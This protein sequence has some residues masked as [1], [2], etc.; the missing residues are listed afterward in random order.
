MART[1][2]LQA[3][4]FFDSK[5]RLQNYGGK[6]AHPEKLSEHLQRG[7]QVRLA[8][9]A[10]TRGLLPALWSSSDGSG[11]ESLFPPPP[12]EQWY[13]CPAVAWAT[14]SRCLSCTCGVFPGPQGRAATEHPPMP[15]QN[16]NTSRHGKNNTCSCRL[17]GNTFHGKLHT[18]SSSA[19]L[20]TQNLQHV[21]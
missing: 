8:A 9:N 20:S 1:L 4:A 10:A 21:P 18:A 17:K 14:N 12:L 11:A 7:R 19:Q 2:L 5:N 13:S 3:A 15:L 6:E 16:L